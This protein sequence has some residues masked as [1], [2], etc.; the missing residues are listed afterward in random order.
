[1]RGK[2]RRQRF[3]MVSA[4]LLVIFGGLFLISIPA[5]AL[6]V[7]F[8]LGSTIALCMLCALGVGFVFFCISTALCIM[9]EG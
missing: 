5:L 3:M 6:L 7:P 2:T 1:M 9:E 4:L 8:S